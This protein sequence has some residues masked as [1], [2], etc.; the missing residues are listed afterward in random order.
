MYGIGVDA[1]QLSSM[2]KISESFIKKY[3]HSS[4]ISEYLKL[5][6]AHEDIRCRFLAS[7]FAVKEAYAKAIGNGFSENV[8]PCEICTLNNEYGAPVISLYGSTLK[9]NGTL[10][11]HVSITHE[12]DLA[13]AFV[14]L[15]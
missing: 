4:E 3:Y 7:R 9:T 15:E 13:I 12:A 2:K 11:C 10:K 5:S 8:K 6:N 1:V 14:V